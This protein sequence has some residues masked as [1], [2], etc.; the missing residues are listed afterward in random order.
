SALLRQH[1]CQN[2][3]RA[4]A[5]KIRWIERKLSIDHE[6]SK[7]VYTT[8]DTTGMI[9][10]FLQVNCRFQ[11][12]A[13]QDTTALIRAFLRVNCRFQVY[14]TQDTTGMIRAFLQVNCRFQVYTTQDTTG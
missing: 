12:Y 8:Q 6:Y 7:R 3:V 5:K 4:R 13:T 9:R 2:Q 11:V 1:S 10:A 14:T